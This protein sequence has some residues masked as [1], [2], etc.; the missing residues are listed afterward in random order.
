MK[1]IIIGA[2]FAGLNAAK[3]IAKLDHV[4]VQ[5]I[6][7]HNYHLFQPLLYQVA[8][9]GLNPADI[10]TPIRAQL[11][12]HKNIEII[13]DEVI[14][15]NRTDKIVETKE[16]TLHYDRLVVATGAKNFY[17]GH[18]EWASLAPGLKGLEDATEIRRRLF[19]AFE[20]AEKAQDEILRKKLMTFVLIGAGPTGVE[21]AGAF[22]EIAH[23]VLAKDFRHINPQQSQVILI[24]AGPR[25]LP[26]FNE[27]MSARAQKDLEAMGVKVLTN[28]KVIDITTDAVILSDGKIE[29]QTI[30]WS[31]GVTPS[32]LAKT[33]G[34]ELERRGRVPVD[35]SM[36]LKEDSSVFVL[37]DL[38]A[39]NVNDGTLPGVASVAIQQGRFMGK[40]LKADLD[41]KAR[42]AFK[43]LDKGQMAT[44]GRKKAVLQVGKISFGGTLA[45]YA[46]LFVHLYYL[47]GFRNRFMV[48]LQWAWSYLTFKRGARII[49]PPRTSEDN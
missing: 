12:P 33:L 2:G 38:A 44:I 46:W 30:A 36:A 9:A 19:L 23:Q 39:F 24:E 8:T 5:I 29:T 18:T 1:V 37:G 49:T 31:A 21:L 41:G 42:P 34:V 25:I 22:A 13:L 26:S 14:S 40:I 4:Q 17:F 32:P 47:I 11:S 27:K 35:Q 6:D 10:A 15:I 20:N 48:F 45:W 3:S 16:R 28:T 43:Y 7:R